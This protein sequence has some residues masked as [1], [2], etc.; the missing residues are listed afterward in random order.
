M[1]ITWIIG[2]G[3]DVNLGLKTGYTD[4]LNRVYL[5][6][7]R[8]DSPL[9]N[10][11]VEKLASAERGGLDTVDLWADLELLLG[12]AT[13]FYGDDELGEFHETFEEMER[14]LADYV[15]QQEERL[16]ETLPADCVKEFKNS[17]ARFDARMAVR[18]QQRFR[19]DGL[20]EDHTHRFISLNYTHALA[21]F[22]EASVDGSD[23]IMRHRAGG[24]FHNERV[25]KPLYVHGSIGE[26]GAAEG[27]IFGVDSPEQVANKAFAGN[28]LFA[29][30]WVKAN[31]NDELYGNANEEV[32]QH[33]I[34]ESDTFCLYGCSLGE[35]DGR[36]WR[37]VG[38]RLVNSNH[39]KLVL[40]VYDM[41]DR[42]GGQHME[43]LHSC[44][45]NRAKFQKAAG[46]DDAAMAELQDRIF[47]LPSRDLFK[48]RDKLELG[49][50]FY[51]DGDSPS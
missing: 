8:S 7:G 15:H 13:E 37:S 23:V 43:Y 20:N 48:L 32:L 22:V 34:S 6:G 12:Q 11:L 36:I 33:L 3:F 18:D 39:V 14:L 45:E 51:E 38:D 26:S 2:N 30:S 28:R 24:V 29:T 4:F 19:L 50:D 46:L 10:V 21:R 27:V 25:E 49:E 44:E 35:T 40:F 17:V 47:F 31:R 16:P 41:P 42:N 9:T 5:P 1:R